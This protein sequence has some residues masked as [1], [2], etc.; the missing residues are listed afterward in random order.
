[1]KAQISKICFKNGNEVLA[2]VF[3][4]GIVYGVSHFI[5]LAEVTIV[6]SYTHV[7][8]GLELAQLLETTWKCDKAQRENPTADNRIAFIRAEEALRTYRK[9]NRKQHPVSAEL[10][11][12]NDS[13]SD[14]LEARLMGLELLGRVQLNGQVETMPPHFRIS[15]DKN[16]IEQLEMEFCKNKVVAE[17]NLQEELRK[18]REP[19][20]GLFNQDKEECEPGTIF[21]FNLSQEWKDKVADGQEIFLVSN[22]RKYAGKLR[23]RHFPNVSVDIIATV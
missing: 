13:L 4:F 6:T 20:A 3:P 5:E 7:E 18:T 15:S 21:S 14:A 11:P 19:F 22:G 1:M 8:I 9:E 17:I 16:T 10:Q 12:K 2:L 23:I